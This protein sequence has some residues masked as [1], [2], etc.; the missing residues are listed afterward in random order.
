MIM[1]FLDLAKGDEKS[2]PHVV[3]PVVEPSDVTDDDDEK[4]F[5]IGQDVKTL[6]ETSKN[7][8]VLFCK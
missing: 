1:I 4:G 2:K 7:L 6:I 8:I 3:A 5:E